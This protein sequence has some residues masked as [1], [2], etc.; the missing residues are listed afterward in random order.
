MEGLKQIFK[1]VLEPINMFINSVNI[2]LF[3]LLLFLWFWFIGSQQLKYVMYEKIDQVNNIIKNDP[4]ISKSVDIY[5]DTIKEDTKFIEK[6]RND[7]IERN[8]YNIDIVYK[9]FGIPILILLIISFFYGVNIFIDFPHK[10]R[11]EQ[12]VLVVLMILAFVTEIVFYFVVIRKFHYISNSSILKSIFD[13][14]KES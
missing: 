8:E 3:V 12:N 5:L 13:K 7:I 1:I 9:Y 2:F 11:I 6:V 4:I 14:P 10:W